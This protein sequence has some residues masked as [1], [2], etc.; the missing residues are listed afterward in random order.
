MAGI[1]AE[2]IRGEREKKTAKIRTLESK[3]TPSQRFQKKTSPVERK[4]RKEKRIILK[5][6]N[7]LLTAPSV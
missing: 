7:G 4:R 5:K 6:K 2:D 3:K 1:G